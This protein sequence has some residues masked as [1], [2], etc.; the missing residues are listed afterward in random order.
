MGLCGMT[1][2]SDLPNLTKFSS[3]SLFLKQVGLLCVLVNE[4]PIHKTGL[5]RLFYYS[6]LLCRKNVFTRTKT[7]N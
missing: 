2:Y 4:I 5:R 3:F 6:Y 7:M 1:K